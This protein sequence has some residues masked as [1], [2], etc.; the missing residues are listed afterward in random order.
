MLL[1]WV[2]F[3]TRAIQD[4]CKGASRVL[5]ISHSGVSD[6]EILGLKILGKGGPGPPTISL[7]PHLKVVGTWYLHA[8]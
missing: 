4:L 3:K 2:R 5:P 1:T 8:F 6:E 7:D